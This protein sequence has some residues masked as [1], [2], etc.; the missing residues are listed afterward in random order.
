MREEGRELSSFEMRE[1]DTASAALDRVRSHAAED[2]RIVLDRSPDP[3]RSLEQAAP[4]EL[5]QV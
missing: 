2:L 3:V 5:R 4:G 1:L